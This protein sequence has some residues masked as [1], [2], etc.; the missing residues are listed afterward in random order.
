MKLME[1]K[2]RLLAFL[3]ATL[4]MVAMFAAPAQAD[5]VS[6][7]LVA[8][9]LSNEDVAVFSSMVSELGESVT[10]AELQA[11]IT[12]ILGDSQVQ[13]LTGAM[14]GNRYIAPEGYSFAIPEGWKLLEEK[15]GVATVVAGQTDETGFMPTISV[16]MLE[17]EQP[18]FETNT[19]KEW[20]ALL[21]QSLA[22][23]LFVA[24]DD[25]PYLDATAHEFVCMHGE[26]EDAMLMQY[27][28]YFN[29]EGKAYLITMTTLA[30][31]AAHD[32]A[33]DAYDSFLA[34]FKISDEG[35]G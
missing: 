7:M 12:E 35:I 15:F 29:K 34:E 25:F 5:W 23:Y 3:I 8:Y 4:I 24:L 13:K 10:E 33:L 26:R 19:Q 2:N 28:L 9:G 21:S 18:D 6:D 22:N 31:E 20:D 27:Q 16:M 1:S 30:E 14:E 17:E 11:L 32:N